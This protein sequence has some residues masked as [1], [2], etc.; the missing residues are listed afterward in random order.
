MIQA[1]FK[2]SVF[3]IAH[4]AAKGYLLALANDGLLP[5]QLALTMAGGIG[6]GF[7][8]YVLSPTLLLKTRVMT[9]PVFREQMSMLRTTA[10]SLKIGFDVITQEGLLALMK[11]SNIFALKRVFD[12][13]TRFY[14]SDVAGKVLLSFS[15]SDVLTPGEKIT[16]DLIGGFFSTVS[17]LPLDVMVA[18]TQDAKKAGVKTSALQMF[19]DELKEG[20][21][22]G[23]KASYLQGFEARL[24][25]VCFTTVAMKTGTGMM[26]DLL[27]NK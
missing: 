17:T 14:F 8:G 1:L 19:K 21:W 25:H 7:Q 5:R 2:G 4:H 11:G 6:G 3:G 9:D 24:L 15:S 18:K 22:K 27:Y 26:Y 23:L 20:G 16:A 10:L 12:W 13:A